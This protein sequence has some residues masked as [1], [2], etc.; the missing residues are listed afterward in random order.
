[1]ASTATTGKN[2]SKSKVT[3]VAT[4]TTKTTAKQVAKPK[5]TTPR[6][7]VL[8]ELSKDMLKA[9]APSHEE[10]A[11]RAFEIWLRKG[12]PNGCD[13][14]NWLEAEEELSPS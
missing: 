9:D 2:N 7:K 8:P 11:Q 6:R 5:K 13:E 1:M 12:C 3:T 10:V 14:A 4:K